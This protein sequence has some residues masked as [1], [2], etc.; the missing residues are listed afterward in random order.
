MR[1]PP[2]VFAKPPIERWRLRPHCLNHIIIHS[3]QRPTFELEKAIEKHLFKPT[4]AQRTGE[5]EQQI[6]T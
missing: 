2:P 4:A 5:L 6:G 3:P 1:G